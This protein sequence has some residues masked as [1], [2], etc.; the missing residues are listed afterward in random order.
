[1][2]DRAENEVQNC[3]IALVRANNKGEIFFSFFTMQLAFGSNK[4][5]VIL[6]QATQKLLLIHNLNDLI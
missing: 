4:A 5:N 6:A 1:M 3:L 2:K